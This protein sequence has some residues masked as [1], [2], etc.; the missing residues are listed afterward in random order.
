[1]KN[2]RELLETELN[3]LSFEDFDNLEKL[4][5]ACRKE[6]EKKIQKIMIEYF[7]KRPYVVYLV[8][9]LMMSRLF[10]MEVP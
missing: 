4:S 7:E 8:A 6:N 10:G 5:R 2:K 1:M 3:L 9:Q